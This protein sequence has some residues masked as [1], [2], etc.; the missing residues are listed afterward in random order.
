MRVEHVLVW[1]RILFN[2]SVARCNVSCNISSK[3][4]FIRGPFPGKER[5]NRIRMTSTKATRKVSPLGAPRASPSS[6]P[7]L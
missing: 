6:L 1:V 7:F 5:R 2:V 3:G 4:I